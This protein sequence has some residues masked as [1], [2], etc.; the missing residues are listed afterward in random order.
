MLAAGGNQSV[1]QQASYRHRPDATRHGG[2]RPSNLLHR[3]EI[4]IPYKPGLAVTQTLTIDANVDHG[5][6]RFYPVSLD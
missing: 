5:R 4:D 2:N 6:T 1:M 3:V